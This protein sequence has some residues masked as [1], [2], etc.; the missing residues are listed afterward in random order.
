MRRNGAEDVRGVSE[1]EFMR[2]YHAPLAKRAPRV[3]KATARRE[4]ERAMEA[5]SGAP[6]ERVLRCLCGH[7]GRVSLPPARA[8]RKFVCSKCGRR[9]S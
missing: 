9:I 8:K 3:S 6:V 7:V 4:L 2:A 1:A 5:A